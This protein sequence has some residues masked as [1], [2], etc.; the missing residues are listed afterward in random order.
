VKPKG[1]TTQRGYG[2]DH[3]RRR[4]MLAPLVAAGLMKCARCGVRI[5]PNQPWDL[6]HTDDRTGYLGPSHRFARDCLAGGNR[7]TAKRKTVSRI[8]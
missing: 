8:W 6:D 7:S 1:S 4:K 2:A 3:Q 5:L